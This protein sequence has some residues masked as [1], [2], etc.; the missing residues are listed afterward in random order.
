[1]NGLCSFVIKGM[2]FNEEGLQFY[3]DEAT[4][5]F[6]PFFF[7]FEYCSLSQYAVCSNVSQ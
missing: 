5:E 1:M 3:L 6:T 2:N 4:Q 7:V